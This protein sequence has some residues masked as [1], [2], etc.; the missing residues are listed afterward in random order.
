MMAA[1]TAMWNVGGPH[2]RKIGILKKSSPSKKDC[3]DKFLRFLCFCLQQPFCWCLVN[4]QSCEG[5]ARSQ[6][7]MLQL[8]GLEFQ[9][10][11]GASHLPIA[12]YGELFWSLFSSAT[13]DRCF[14]QGARDKKKGACVSR[15]PLGSSRLGSRLCGAIR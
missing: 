6:P 10:P 4:V 5:R 7:V 13:D 9:L 2:F 8:G 11:L 15:S 3:D 12:F 14:L 1:L